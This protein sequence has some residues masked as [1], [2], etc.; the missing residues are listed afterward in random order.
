MWVLGD[1]GCWWCC[2]CDARCGCGCVALRPFGLA[3]LSDQI[4]QVSS[5]SRRRGSQQA[6]LDDGIV[7]WAKTSSLSFPPDDLFEQDV[8]RERKETKVNGLNI[9]ASLV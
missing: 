1:A 7:W 6:T 5:V 4:P 2:C 9:Q 8:K 3:S